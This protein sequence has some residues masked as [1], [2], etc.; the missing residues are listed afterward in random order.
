[1]KYLHVTLREN[2]P[3][4]FV[5]LQQ[6]SVTVTQY[7]TRFVDL[8]RHATIFIPTEWER[9]RRFIERITYLIKLQMV[10]EIGSDISFQ[11]APNIAR[12]IEMVLTQEMRHVSDKRPHQ[13]IGFSGASSGGRGNFGRDHPPRQFQSA[14]QAS[15]GVSGSRS[16]IVSHP[17]QL[18]YSVPL[19]PISAPPIQSHQSGYPGRH[20]QSQ[21]QQSQQ[22]RACYTCGDLRQVARFFP[23]SQGSMQQ[24]GSHA[25]IPALTV[26]PPAQPARGMGQIARGGGQVVRG[27]G[28]PIRGRPRDVAPGSGA[29]PRFYAFPAR[30]EVESC[31]AVIT[32][33]VPGFHRNTSV[34]FAPGSTYSY[35]SSYFSS[36]L[37]APHDSLSASMCVSILVGESV[38]VDHVYS[39][40]VFT[41]GSLET[42]VDLLLLDMVDFDV[43]L[44]MD[45]L[46]P[47]QLQSAKTEED[48][49]KGD[50]SEG[51]AEEDNAT[52]KTDDEPQCEEISMNGKTNKDDVQ[53]DRILQK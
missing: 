39:S 46:L 51:Y 16:P 41:I 40:C 25:M 7:E 10:K 35:V 23:R 3:R 30:P 48:S 45:W 24:H 42:S 44:G 5:C 26:P 15:H 22:L 13:F 11:A 50:L 4:Q 2:Y 17:D 33:I 43:I 14:L 32:C 12:R 1:M 8:A 37:V 19:A 6:S 53:E 38:V 52:L 27:G 49:D 21:G 47:Y 20:G 9:V 28:Q 36:Y 31:D 18:A 34:L 29:Q